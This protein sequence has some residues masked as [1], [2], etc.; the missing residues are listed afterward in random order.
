MINDVLNHGFLLDT[1]LKLTRS[2]GAGEETEDVHF[3]APIHESLNAERF[4]GQSSPCSTPDKS[5]DLL[6]LQQEKV[7]LPCLNLL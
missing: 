3:Q 1:A 2:E 5:R 6:Q 7:Q 4:N